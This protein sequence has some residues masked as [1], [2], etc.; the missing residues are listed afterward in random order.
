MSTPASAWASA[1]SAYSSRVASLSTRPSG[2]STPQ[3]P[4]SVN[5]SRHRSLITVSAS[6]TSATTSVIATLRMPSGSI[7]PEPTASLLLGDA[8]EHHAAEPE[9][10]RL[11]GRLAQRVAG[12]LDDAGHRRDRHAARRSP[13]GRT[14][15][16]PAGAASTDVSATSRRSAGRACAAG[17]AGPAGPASSAATP[18]SSRGTRPTAGRGLA[19]GRLGDRL[20]GL[21]H[22]R[23][24]RG[25]EVGE[26][27]GE[28]RRR[29]ASGASTSTR[30]PCSSAVLAVAGPITAITVDGC[31]LPAMPTRLRTVDDDVKTTASNLPVLIA[32][33]VGAGGGAARTVRYAVTSST[34]QPRSIRPA[35]RFSVAMSARGRK[36]RLIGSS[37]VVVLRPVLEQPG[38]RLLARRHQVGA[39]A[40][41]GDRLGGLLADRGDLEAGEGARV[42]AV[43]LELLAHRLHR[44]DRGEGD[45]L[46]AAL[47]QAADGLVHLL[48]VARRLD[49]D[50]R[51][52]LG[53]GAVAAQPGDSE[54]A[55]S[56]VRGT[57]TRQPNSGLV[58]NHDSVSRSS[59]TVADHDDG[60]RRHPRGARVGGDVGQRRGDRGLLGGG[61]DAGHR[62]RRLRG[63]GRRRSAPWRCRRSCRRAESST[64]V[65]S[66]AYWLQSTLSCR[67]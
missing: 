40:P 47:D 28:H 8:E 56:L 63:R 26:R 62:D 18:R 49:R 38:G 7:A 4:W 19:L 39:Q 11:G 14:A 35:T 25:A 57:R 21:E 44:V 10:G 67:R 30:R 42:E 66:S 50:R 2:V 17:A 60:G 24:A 37:S 3:W 31:G 13:R 32:S 59:T 46:V 16:A 64:S 34:S 61:A 22:R 51:H 23:P 5:S 15:A 58:S 1:I 29:P 9:L 6:P 52:L 33:R 55:C 65:R 20:A 53:H 41:G 36:T 43:L 54:P 45:P 48:R 12:V 27:V